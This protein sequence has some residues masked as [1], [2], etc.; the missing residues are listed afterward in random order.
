MLFPPRSRTAR[1]ILRLR[2]FYDYDVLDSTIQPFEKVR[3]TTSSHFTEHPRTR[4][5]PEQQVCLYKQDAY[6]YFDEQETVRRRYRRA[7]KS[8]RGKSNRDN[9]ADKVRSIPRAHVALYIRAQNAKSCRTFTLLSFGVCGSA[10]YDRSRVPMIEEP[11]RTTRRDLGNDEIARPSSR[12]R[13]PFFLDKTLAK[14]EA[15]MVVAR[16][17]GSAPYRTCASVIHP[18]TRRMGGFTS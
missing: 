1:P 6:G 17:S 10:I 13:N 5:R 14:T 18:K 8:A 7:R 3:V 16:R 2:R 12:G 4:K 15:R 9:N 11:M